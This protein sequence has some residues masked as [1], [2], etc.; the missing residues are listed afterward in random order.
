MA[1]LLTILNLFIQQLILKIRWLLEHSLFLTS[2]LT[3]FDAILFSVFVSFPQNLYED[4]EE[5]QLKA[6][7]AASLQETAHTSNHQNSGRK[8]DS[9][10]E[11]DS[12]ELET[13]DSD[14]ETA[15]NSKLVKLKVNEKTENDKS[16]L[17][18]R[19]ANENKAENWETYLGP[20]NGKYSDLIIRFP[21]GTREQKS[22]PAE[23][24][25]K[26]N[27]LLYY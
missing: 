11:E 24:K 12:E 15:S 17:S 16:K 23:S 9:D 5:A 8:G 20:D 19:P 7:I 27:C 1:Q 22:F 2:V 10:E 21:D 6:A 3:Y 25:L 18:P 4:T 14:T 26:V 13:F